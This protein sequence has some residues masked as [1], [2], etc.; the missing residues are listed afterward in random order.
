MRIFF[1]LEHSKG[2]S[3]DEKC[4]TNQRYEMCPQ[5]LIGKKNVG[6]YKVIN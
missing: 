2:D 4:S 3:A 6:R 1:F 5:K